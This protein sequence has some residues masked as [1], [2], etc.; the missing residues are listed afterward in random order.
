M[1]WTTAKYDGETL[2]YPRCSYH[3][4]FCYPGSCRAVS[5]KHLTTHAAA[6]QCSCPA[7]FLNGGETGCQR[8]D[9]SSPVV[10]PDID[11][12]EFRAPLQN[13]KSCTRG[14]AVYDVNYGSNMEFT[15]NGEMGQQFNFDRD[16]FQPKPAYIH[17]RSL[18]VV[19]SR[20]EVVVEHNGVNK[21]HVFRGECSANE[22]SHT[23]CSIASPCTVT[24]NVSCP[25][26]VPF[27][28]NDLVHVQ[29]YVLSSGFLTAKDYDTNTKPTYNFID[30]GI[31]KAVASMYIDYTKPTNP[32]PGAQLA[33]VNGQLYLPT[34]PRACFD[35]NGWTDNRAIAQFS[36]SLH[37]YSRSFTDPVR[38]DATPLDADFVPDPDHATRV[39]VDLSAH[40]TGLYAVLLHVHDR[41]GNVQVARRN[42]YYDQDSVLEP[43]PA[44]PIT[45][46]SLYN[47]LFL[48]QTSQIEVDFA[49][50]LRVRVAGDVH[51]TACRAL[52]FLQPVLPD[53]DHVEDAYD[54]PQGL[55]A[56]PGTANK[57][58]LV[59][60]EWMVEH[61][62]TG[63]VVV[64]L[65]NLDLATRARATGLDLKPQD[66][67]RIIIT[68]YD[69]FGR[70][71]TAYKHIRSAPRDPVVQDLM[72][73]GPDG[74]RN[75]FFHHSERLHSANMVLTAFD[76][77]AGLECIQYKL[78]A[79][80]TIG[81]SPSIL[82]VNST[83]F[84][85]DMGEALCAAAAQPSTD[86]KCTF[87]F[88]NR[89][90]CQR[91]E[92]TISLAP[93]AI[94]QKELDTH[95]NRQ[96]YV[97]FTPKANSGRTAT[98][99]LH[100]D[101][102]DSPPPTPSV[103]NGRPGT[104]LAQVHPGHE[105]SV[106]WLA[107]PD[108]QSGLRYLR[109]SWNHTCPTDQWDE[110]GSTWKQVDPATDHATF[111]AEA[112]GTYCVC[113]V[114]VN[115]AMLRSAPGCNPRIMVDT[116]QPVI[117]H[118]ALTPVVGRYL[119]RITNVHV[120]VQVDQPDRVRNVSVA[121]SSS[122]ERLAD[123]DI[124][125]WRPLGANFGTDV[126]LV[127]AHDAQP[128]V[129]LAKIVALNGRSSEVATS[130]PFV[131]DTQ[132]PTL[133]DNCELSIDDLDPDAGLTVCWPPDCLSDDVA[134]LDLS[135]V[136]LGLRAPASHNLT[137]WPLAPATQLQDRPGCWRV[138]PAGPS[139]HTHR[140]LAH[141]ALYEAVLQVRDVANHSATFVAPEPWGYT[142]QQWPIGTIQAWPT[143]DR[144]QL[145]GQLRGWNQAQALSV[146]VI[147]K[148]ATTVVIELPVPPLNASG[149]FCLDLAKNL[150]SYNMVY[151][152][153]VQYQAQ[154]ATSR[155]S[156]SVPCRQADRPLV[157]LWP[158]I[159]QAHALGP[160]CL[161]PPQPAFRVAGDGQV[162]HAGCV[163]QLRVLPSGAPIA[164]AWTGKADELQP[165]GISFIKSWLQ[166]ADD[167]VIVQRQ[168]SVL[169]TS[170]GPIL[171]QLPAGQ[172]V[173]PCV[174]ACHEAGCWEPECAPV[175]AATVADAALTAEKVATALTA[176]TLSVQWQHPAVVG[177]TGVVAYG[178]AVRRHGIG[179]TAS[180]DVVID[181]SGRCLAPSSVDVAQAP[182]CEWTDAAV[183]VQVQ[184]RNPDLHHGL[185]V[186][187]HTYGQDGL[188]AQTAAVVVPP[189]PPP[190]PGALVSF[191]DTQRPSTGMVDAVN[192]LQQ[193]VIW[194]HGTPG[195]WDVQASTQP[196]WVPRELSLGYTRV[197]EGTDYVNAGDFV[198]LP[199]PAARAPFFVCVRGPIPRHA[200]GQPRE[201][202]PGTPVTCT[203]SPVTVM[204]PQTSAALATAVL[205]DGEP[206][207]PVGWPL[208]LMV[209]DLQLVA[210][211]AAE[212]AV[213]LG[214]PDSELSSGLVPTSVS[215]LGRIL[216]PSASTTLAAGH[217]YCA[218]VTC[219]LRSGEVVRVRSNCVRIEPV[220]VTP[221]L[222]ATWVDDQGHPVSGTVGRPGL[223]LRVSGGQGLLHV[224]VTAG[225]TVLA[226]QGSVWEV[227]ARVLPP[228]DL[229]VGL[230]GWTAGGQWAQ[231]RSVLLQVDAHGPVFTGDRVLLG[232]GHH[233]HAHAGN[234]PLAVQWP[235][236]VDD[237]AGVASYRVEL[238][239]AYHVVDALE[240]HA[241]ALAVNLSLAREHAPPGRD[242]VVAVVACDHAAQCTELESQP[243][244][245]QY[246]APRR[247]FVVDGNNLAEDASVWGNPRWIEASWGGFHD[248]IAGVCYYHWG[249][250]TAPNKADVVDWRTTHVT[251]G[252]AVAMLPEHI[253]LFVT[254]RA[255]GCAGH[256]TWAASDGFRVVTS[257]PTVTKGPWWN[258]LVPGAT[259]QASR[260][261][262]SLGLEFEHPHNVSTLTA[263][264]RSIETEYVYA[265]WTPVPPELAGR[266]E[267]SRLDL[268]DGDS[269]VADVEFCNQA[270]HCA[271]ATTPPLAID[272]TP[273]PVGNVS[274]VAF[275]PTTTVLTVRLEHGAWDPDQV[276]D[277]Q[278]KQFSL[279][280]G[281]FPLANDLAAGQ[282]QIT[283]PDAQ[284][285]V[286]L[287]ATLQRAPQKDQVVH[288]AV[289]SVNR[290]G[291][292]SRPAQAEALVAVAD[293]MADL[294][295]LRHGC[296]FFSCGCRV[297]CGSQPCS[298]ELAKRARPCQ[299]V[300]ADPR[301][302]VSDAVAPSDSDSQLLGLGDVVVA[303]V[304][305][306]R[307]GEHLRVECTG[308]QQ[309][310]QH[311]GDGVVSA[312]E[313]PFVIVP[314]D[315]PVMVQT[316]PTNR[317]RGV[318][319]IV[320]TDHLLDSTNV[321]HQHLKTGVVYETMC[322][323]WVA[324]DAY[325]DVRS[326]GAE[327]QPDVVPNAGLLVGTDAPAEPFAPD[328]DVILAAGR[329]AKVHLRMRQ[330]MVGR[331]GCEWQACGHDECAQGAV[332]S[333]QE[334]HVSIS[335]SAE[336]LQRIVGHRLRLAVVCPR[337]T[338]GAPGV[339]L[340]SVEP[341]VVVTT[342]TPARAAPRVTLGAQ[343][344]TA[345]V[346]P[347]D[348][349]TFAVDYE[350]EVDGL[351]RLLAAVHE[352][353]TR[354]PPIDKY[355][356]LEANGSEFEL[357]GLQ[358]A[359]GR[360]YT[361][362][363]VAETRA[364]VLSPVGTASTSVRAQAQPLFMVT[365]GGPE[366]VAAPRLGDEPTL[367]PA[368]QCGQPLVSSATSVAPAW[369]TK[370][371][372]VFGQ[373]APTGGV[374]AR[375]VV[376]AA[377]AC[378]H[379][380]LHQTVALEAA[381]YQLTVAFACASEVNAGTVVGEV[382][383]GQQVAL[384]LQCHPWPR[385]LRVAARVRGSGVQEQLEVRVL[386]AGKQHTTLWL[387]EVSLRR[388]EVSERAKPGQ[389]VQ[390][391]PA[392][393]GNPRG[394]CFQW[395]TA[396]TGDV[397]EYA[398]GTQPGGQD[399][400]G[401]QAV[402]RATHACSDAWLPG[403][404]EVHVTVLACDQ[405]NRC[406]RGAGSG[407]VAASPPNVTL[408]LEHQF[409]D[410][411]LRVRA[412]ARAVEAV[413]G[414][415]VHGCTLCVGEMCE[416]QL[417]GGGVMTAS[418]GEWHLEAR[419]HEPVA[420][421]PPNGAML[422]VQVG[423]LA[424][425]GHTGVARAELEVRAHPVSAA[426]GQVWVQHFAAAP[427]EELARGPALPNYVD[428]RNI[429]Q[430][431]VRWRWD[432]PD[433]GHHVSFVVHAQKHDGSVLG[434]PVEVADEA[435]VAL[436]KVVGATQ[437][438]AGQAV[439]LFVAPIL[440]PGQ[441]PEAQQNVTVHVTGSLALAR[442]PGP[443]ITHTSDGLV[444][445]D[446]LPA[447]T[448]PDAQIDTYGAD[449]GS[450]PGRS[451]VVQDVAGHGAW[452]PLGEG[453]QYLTGRAYTLIAHV[454]APTGAR[455]SR[456]YNFVL[457]AAGSSDDAVAAAD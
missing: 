309:G 94:L 169:D 177:A 438:P 87:D 450:A 116:S 220:V 225:S 181:A 234:E 178:L 411:T 388:V 154:P 422:E 55:F 184:L 170:S 257:A 161:G 66:E 180:D 271:Q 122:T 369:T 337:A 400:A 426:L 105:F 124:L 12:C 86:C 259:A 113:V 256:E 188:V 75:V 365:V 307:P 298:P 267:V 345:T 88:P 179:S 138:A 232:Q 273:A 335:L 338:I 315:Q 312:Q 390:M 114:S 310:A 437:L 281:T 125:S 381:L 203:S 350:P 226:Q 353:G 155:Q 109:Y 414:A 119:P 139:N 166:S 293:G 440:A 372:V 123:P 72:L 44:K 254:V 441:A 17:R 148:P 447:V 8:L 101:V 215:H 126:A 222:E 396:S 228:G 151:A 205:A 25:F 163:A 52:P 104:L 23:P 145:C 283:G 268:R 266:F 74:E 160:Q 136:R 60:F 162:T 349:I 18:G 285:V 193:L 129:A 324:P 319:Q 1:A 103:Y 150:L 67:Y 29:F 92:H 238:R 186:L 286:V 112:D 198:V 149:H 199:T 434:K 317:E 452:L 376:G 456:A 135:T 4:P 413:A 167:T 233:P 340:R 110:T 191:G 404:A 449:V 420:A 108:L 377:L 363:V 457:P 401:W 211:D 280:V 128:V 230:Q 172:P 241:D 227:D 229:A 299:Q 65:T 53:P 98:K 304:Q 320:A 36:W 430:D 370:G 326:N 236:A 26:R 130:A 27:V 245:L 339:V 168:L 13:P 183:K 41:A 403:N 395:H 443:R 91:I 453:Q 24:S 106:W 6:V 175:A 127:A 202:L 284:G 185:D 33:L 68:G 141:A 62:K 147:A 176:G 429:S 276:P 3:A 364:G 382:R 316:L 35:H 190:P 217:E 165:Q 95:H 142:V 336:F 255:V 11:H 290:A 341:L 79:R 410:Q 34:Q 384:R 90:T 57:C 56:R 197:P 287:Q 134:G 97:E 262:L 39:C 156:A 406:S 348:R 454:T 428:G 347:L 425:G 111:R 235:P 330:S 16:G 252:Q 153:E 264:V 327:V 352:A 325:F 409:L 362:S 343:L 100:F 344:V 210:D 244:A 159:R 405:L 37:R 69:V 120:R 274:N 258:P 329:P 374:A 423:C 194:L 328:A 291:L 387:E 15:F 19:D 294:L 32:D 378:A 306:L 282:A 334:T 333:A 31:A 356:S 2:C 9:G 196:A 311:P 63:A 137:V 424:A 218:G 247:G 78:Y 383:V 221:T 251:E 357:T 289:T 448:P 214:P 14:Q 292:R 322:R 117:N 392:V 439:V 446:L 296:L 201:A 164:V 212:C 431:V 354:A 58:G 346:T 332:A 242:Y 30:H 50:H 253:L 444:F 216:L 342:D 213:T 313:Y 435:A 64:P 391:V 389:E 85:E 133:A 146:K 269:V 132:P 260:S 240:V 73:Q 144:S 358:L 131:V 28:E 118:V 54:Q 261:L 399:V 275:G 455:V 373:A 408:L 195:D 278:V 239:H 385:E 51:T 360:Q 77:V 318:S 368:Q 38:M 43:V 249:V 7:G 59:R 359:S 265:D 277:G 407:I 96:F 375:P 295:L 442:V 76:G 80:S 297:D 82:L 366:V 10:A 152:L 246:D 93:F 393:A 270:G 140:G 83:H 45:V 237:I 436:H 331:S 263:R 40:G 248:P 22:R 323:V 321:A 209:R 308:Q 380:A 200:D 189:P 361:V 219:S 84:V 288:V 107:P 451:D 418:D 182:T 432:M 42:L 208:P 204:G 192:A 206:A 99:T 224:R 402:G 231:A 379:S 314:S 174:Q 272:S 81:D 143:M 394:A 61:L 250:G 102:D 243:F 173:I 303:S 421:L 305:G 187:I 21:T 157:Q 223:V 158:Y 115:Q 371:H 47:D 279:T 49:E 207:W 171:L 300:A 121:L 386:R 70:N 433:V 48:H 355:Q 419:V 351:R 397:F 71:V 398:L 445:V 89:T 367:V 46:T 427:R 416:F 302:S 412:R 20:V 301:L 5:A 417:E 415:S